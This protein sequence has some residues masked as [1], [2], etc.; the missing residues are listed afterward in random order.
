MWD[1]ILWPLPQTG[2]MWLE[3]EL[4]SNPD[5]QGVFCISTSYRNEPNTVEG[6]H[7]KIFPMIEFE[8]KGTMLDL[9]TFE[10][11]MLHHFNFGS[12]YE[13][14]YEHACKYYN[15]N[16]IDHDEETKLCDDFEPAVFLKNFPKRTAPFWNMKHAGNGIFNKIDVLLYGQETI[17]SAERATDV[18]EMRHHF[19]TVSNGNY[20]KKL[21]SLFGKERVKRELNKFLSFDF[22]PRFGGGIGVT[23]FLRALEMQP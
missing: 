7:E 9:L 5:Y 13:I 12:S 17:G 8:A 19:E 23:R 2:Q 21:F 10:K 15:T 4:L 18:D 20:R 11:E 16:E 3:H 1:Q 22:F 6:R 14:D